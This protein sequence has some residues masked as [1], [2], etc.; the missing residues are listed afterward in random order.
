MTN[1]RPN[2]M[3][4]PL[5]VY[6]ADLQPTDD[7]PFSDSSDPQTPARSSSEIKRRGEEM[8][9]TT[10][11]PKDL[12]M[13]PTESSSPSTLT[14]GALARS[15]L[16]SSRT[17]TNHQ[18]LQRTLPQSKL[19][20]QGVN[21]LSRNH[22]DTMC[23]SDILAQQQQPSP[24]FHPPAHTQRTTP[25]NSHRTPYVIHS[26]AL[27]PNMDIGDSLQSLLN[28]ADDGKHYQCIS[29]NQQDD[30]GQV[31][32]SQIIR[33]YFQNINGLRLAD[34][35]TDI[36]DVFYQMEAIRADIF[37][38]AETKLDCRN[39]Q[40]KTIL[41]RAKRKVWDHCKI[42][43][44]SSTCSWHSLHKPGGTLLGITG[45]MV[46]RVRK[47]IEDDLGR[48]TGVELLGRDGR[49]VVIICAYQVCQLHGPAGQSTAYQQQ[50][51]LLRQQGQLQPSPRKQFILDLGVLV[52]SYHDHNC[53]IILMG[54]FNEVIGL[55]R[56][57]W[58]L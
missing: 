33:I 15:L 4:I 19:P 29:P 42:T 56:T 7:I 5:P 9:A 6:P 32:R 50:V 1:E 41:H 39:Q 54:D 23:P 46:G 52:K 26:Q 38:F 12:A 20:F 27:K 55:N 13:T 24:N 51:A 22:I 36:L 10:N 47:T 8:S 58:R 2:A 31:W 30:H 48:W 35:G 14:T 21:P 18:T 57:A 44:S 45:P 43:T 34:N 16:T 3:G 53:D 25:I 49:N 37:G 28:G 17:P 40:V 11:S